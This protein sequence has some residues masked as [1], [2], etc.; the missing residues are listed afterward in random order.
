MLSAVRTGVLHQPEC[1]K[2]FDHH[3]ARMT[4]SGEHCAEGECIS[5]YIHLVPF[6]MWAADMREAAA[7]RCIHHVVYLHQFC[8]DLYQGASSCCLE[9]GGSDNDCI[10]AYVHTYLGSPLSPLTP[11]RNESQSWSRERYVRAPMRDIT[12]TS[13]SLSPSSPFLSL[14]PCAPAGSG[15]HHVQ[16]WARSWQ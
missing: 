7:N 13:P 11:A 2:L 3:R 15:H 9:L 16:V 14:P 1:H 8:F 12:P 10:E 4:A 5:L 6:H